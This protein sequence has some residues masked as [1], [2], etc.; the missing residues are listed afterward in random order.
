MKESMGTPQGREQEN[1]ALLSK[2]LGQLWVVQIAALA[3][4]V[5][6][7][8]PSL[9][10]LVGWA[11]RVIALAA[12]FILLQ[13]RPVTARYQKA[14]VCQLVVVACG[15]VSLA[16]V[17]MIVNLAGSVFGLFAIYY[18]HYAHAEVVESFDIRL[19]E[20]WRALVIWKVVV[21]L[22]SGMLAIMLVVIGV[23]MEQSAEFLLLAGVGTAA[24]IG[25]AL[26]I[27]YL[28]YLKKSRE[29]FPG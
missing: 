7:A 10:L 4:I 18:E 28:I 16:G 9:S 15:L 29:W 21:G 11:N 22:L 14:G 5:L 17:N 26:Q 25:L 2:Y 24:A 12:G 8:V 1:S 6:A 19:A 3:A 27:V 20:K 13:L 23:M